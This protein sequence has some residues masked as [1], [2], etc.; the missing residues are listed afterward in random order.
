M[1]LKVG[2]MPYGSLFFQP[3]EYFDCGYC[4]TGNWR[5][6]EVVALACTDACV[7][8]ADCLRKQVAVDGNGYCVL[9]HVP[10][11]VKPPPPITEDEEQ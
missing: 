10:I 1:S 9:C 7:F 2:K 8:K 4:I 6:Q 3:G 11:I 5:G